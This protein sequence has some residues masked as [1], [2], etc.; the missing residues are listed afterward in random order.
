MMRVFTLLAFVLPQS[1]SAQTTARVDSFYSPSISSTSQYAY[2]LPERYDSLHAYP[3]LYLLHGYGGNHRNWTELTNLSTYSA[4]LGLIIIMPNGGNSWYVNSMGR[5]SDRYEDMIITDLRRH[6]EHRF[7][8]DTTRRA[9]AGLSMGGYGA[10]MLAL[11]HPQLFCFAGSL[12][13]ALSIPG[14]M[15]FSERNRPERSLTNL[16]VVF[17][18]EKALHKQHDLFALYRNTIPESLPRLYFVIGTN[19]G[20]A[21][22]LPA[23]RALS[24][25]LRSYGARYEYHE[26][27]GAHNW[28]YWEKEIQPLL[29]RM[30]EVFHERNR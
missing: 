26:T 6:I 27:P 29:R 16:K 9:I 28:K 20:F 11:R 21:T 1:V 7:R 25:S 12:S 3:I 10:I 19:D 24:D 17:G 22:F 4:P 15:E 13:G 2:L 23:H 18:A 8:V 30:V 5:P 14:S